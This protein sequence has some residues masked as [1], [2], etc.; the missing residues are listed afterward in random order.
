M[1]C[2]RHLSFGK[3]GL[4]SHSKGLTIWLKISFE[5]TAWFIWGLIFGFKFELVQLFLYF[6][7][8]KV[9]L[10]FFFLVMLFLDTSFL[11]LVQI[12]H[13]PFLLCIFLNRTFSLAGILLEIWLKPSATVFFPFATPLH[14][15]QLLI[16][17]LDFL[18]HTIF[19]LRTLQLFLFHMFNLFLL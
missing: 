17:L 15:Q 11:R 2:Q 13:L 12:N 16:L 1:R 7:L 19:K 6:C 5:L 4:M 14:I 8:E 9:F 3:S 10:F 18:P